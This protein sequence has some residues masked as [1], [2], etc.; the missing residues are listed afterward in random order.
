MT[1][2]IGSH[3]PEGPGGL[4][5]VNNGR[6][7]HGRI[8][9]FGVVD[10]IE[11]V[12]EGDHGDGEADVHQLLLG[13]AR[14]LDSREILITD[15]P[16]GLYH[17][18]DQAHQR[19]S[20]GI[21]RGLARTNLPYH[22]G[23]EPCGLRKLGVRGRAVIAARQLTDEQLDRFLILLAQAAP[24]QYRVGLQHGLQRRRSEGA[25][26]GVGIR[27]LAG[28][29]FDLSV[30]LRRRARG[31]FDGGNGDSRHSD[32]SFRGLDEKD[33][34]HFMAA[35]GSL[36]YQSSSKTYSFVSSLPRRDWASWR[37]WLAHRK[38]P[39]SSIGSDQ[40]SRTGISLSTARKV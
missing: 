22:G 36:K 9:Q 39:S 2:N 7:G 24:G 12:G 1:S 33:G 3:G 19:I 32:N 6:S 28:G 8:V 15:R 11:D 23:R 31:G 13:I 25:D 18:A 14:S 38:P 5:R 10:A 4:G 40:L 29:L 26:D 37:T 27:H 30:E 20:L 17:L 34:C 16:A 35:S 21:P